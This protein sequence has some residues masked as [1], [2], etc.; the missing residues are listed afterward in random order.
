MRDRNFVSEEQIELEN[1]LVFLRDYVEKTSKAW[2]EVLTELEEQLHI[3]KDSNWKNATINAI[4]IIKQKLTEIE[5]Q[6]KNMEHTYENCHNLTCRLKERNF[7]YN[8]ALEDFY[9]GLADELLW[10]RER[11]GDDAYMALCPKCYLE[12]KARK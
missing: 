8:L 9:N 7:G 6:E 4:C 10:I 3:G 11:F 2:E 1:S 5:E 12:F